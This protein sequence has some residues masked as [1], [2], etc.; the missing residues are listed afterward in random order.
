MIARHRSLSP[1]TAR[2]DAE[3]VHVA[4]RLELGL[5]Y[6][7]VD[8]ILAEQV[9][10]DLAE[11]Y[12]EDVASN[13]R[14][15]ASYRYAV[16]LC[17][18]APHLGWSALRDSGPRERARLAA[19]AGGLALMGTLV[20][21]AS[22]MR[23]GPP[24]RLLTNPGGAAD[25]IVVNNMRP[26]QLPVQVVDA[27]GRRLQKPTVGYRWTSGAPLTLS[28]SG[29][30][31][32]SENGDAVVRAAAGNIATSLTVHCRPVSRLET[33]TW[34]TLLLPG[35][36][37][38]LPFTAFGQDDRP[39][40]E[41][42]G[43]VRVRDSTVATLSG[44]TIRPLAP[45]ETNVVLSVGDHAATIRV[46][47]HERVRA[48]TGLRPDQRFVAVAVHLARGDT[49]RYALPMGIYWLKYIPRRLGDAPPTIIADVT[50]GPGYGMSVYRLPL[51][52]YAT[53]CALNT[54]GKV[55]LAHGVRGAAFVDGTLAVERVVER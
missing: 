26:V 37:Q 47:V 55:T 4:S 51:D 25:G 8:P 16:D 52:E 40:T 12:D 50:C 7:G 42:H 48:F 5:R 30:I 3:R 14:A 49:V 10:G 38:D 46:L 24:A 44:S 53:Y 27:K 9:L 19:C 36:P 54:D 15:A 33:N 22:D 13:G 28:P 11:A 1:A 45:G 31:T 18:S 39:V 23:D 32:C 35:V 43:T 6:L 41:L 34:I 29:V 21:T 17:R 2:T 20:M